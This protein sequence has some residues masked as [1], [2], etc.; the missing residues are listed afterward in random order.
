MSKQPTPS[1]QSRTES[2]SETDAYGGS[3]RRLQGKKH[4]RL[5][6]PAH[7]PSSSHGEVRFSTRKAAKV[8][9][10]NEDDDDIFNDDEDILTPNYWPTGPEENSPAIDVVLDHRLRE[11]TSE[12]ILTGLCN[13]KLTMDLGEEMA[14]PGRDD[15]EYYVSASSF[16]C[17]I[18][19]IHTQIMGFTD[20]M[21]RQGSYPRHLGNKR[22]P[23][24][25]SRHSKAR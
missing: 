20:Q 11:D 22:C 5:L 6:Q 4:R 1:G 2:E 17:F 10:Y 24:L 12:Y 21:A 7:R 8:S 14:N 15:F 13:S 9:T 3:R 16:V 23:S 19:M 25:L 18:C